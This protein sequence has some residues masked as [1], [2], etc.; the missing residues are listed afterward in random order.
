MR[1]QGHNVYYLAGATN[2][3]DLKNV[4]SLSRNIGVRFN[5]NQMRIPLISSR[6]QIH[7]LLNQV[8]FDVLHVQMP[9]SPFLAAR[10]VNAANQ[11]TAVVGTFHIVPKYALVTLASHALSWLCF[12]SQRR[13]DQVVSVSP[14]AQG[15]ARR[16]F[17]LKSI[18]LPNA[19]EYQRFHT[20]QPLPERSAD[21]TVQILFLGKLVPR[22]GCLVLLQAINHLVRQNINRQLKVT[23]CGDGPLA[24][25]L[26]RFVSNSNLES[27]VS[28]AGFISEEEKPQY[29]ASA[30]ITVFP[31]LGGESFGIVLIEAMASGRAAVL[32]GNN[33]GY[34][35]VLGSCPGDVLFDPQDPA[36][37]ATK[38]SSIIQNK[39]LRHEVANWQASRAKDFDIDLVG[40]Q[41]L[42][43]YD[44]ALQQRRNVR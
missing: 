9:Y 14:A 17:H 10:I 24:V 44:A 26:K 2:R 23:I 16:A 20:A 40:S 3:S 7:Q 5:G 36:E 19:I 39:A 11:D 38:L 42:K 28:F 41:L 29:Y 33:D 22:K 35:S 15:F 27:Y 8:H 6:R 37:L 18:I 12:N 30:D 34:R 13:F 4:Y 43:I 21:K 1:S 31:S 25:E 32:A